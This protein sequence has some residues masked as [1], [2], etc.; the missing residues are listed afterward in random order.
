MEHDEE[1]HDLCDLVEDML[2][3]GLDKTL[4][5]EMLQGSLVS[6][7]QLDSLVGLL[8]D[9]GH[10]DLAEEISLGIHHPTLADDIARQQ[11]W[12]LNDRCNAASHQEPKKRWDKKWVQRFDK[13]YP[14]SLVF[15]RPTMK[16]YHDSL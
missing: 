13:L 9:K 6:D 2:D 4:V 14:K 12:H 3:E 1:V 15:L 8:E 11:P 10:E 16:E 7:S 5:W